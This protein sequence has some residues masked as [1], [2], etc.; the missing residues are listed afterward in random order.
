MR[1][2]VGEKKRK[3]KYLGFDVIKRRRADDGE[4][5]KEDIGLRIGQRSETVV[6]LLAGGIPQTQANRSTIHHHTRG[7]VIEAG[8]SV[9]MASDKRGGQREKGSG[10]GYEHGWDVFPG[11]GVGCVGNQEACLAVSRSQ[12]MLISRKS[13]HCAKERTTHLANSTITGNYTLYEISY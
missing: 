7:V 10:A 1:R 3:E 2:L 9:N 6:I 12:S 13:K 11:E 8:K 4:A 5:D